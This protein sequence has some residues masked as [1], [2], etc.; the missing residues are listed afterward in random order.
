[1]TQNFQ[2]NE[3]VTGK[4]QFFEMGPFFTPHSICLYIGLWEGSFFWKRF[5]FFRKFV[6][7][8]S[9]ENVQNFQYCHIKTYR[10][11]KRRIILKI[12]SIVFQKNIFKALS[13]DFKLKPLR[14]AFSS[15]KSKTNSKFAVKLAER[16]KRSFCVCLMNHLFQTSVL[17]NMWQWNI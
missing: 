3:I 4:I 7:K 5:S 14:K 6:L 13:V 1:M 17:L 9:T 10:S 15:V 11:F 12:L 2:K 16:S 8:L